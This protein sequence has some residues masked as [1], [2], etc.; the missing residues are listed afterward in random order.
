MAGRMFSFLQNF[1]QMLKKQKGIFWHIFPFG[2]EKKTILEGGEKLKWEKKIKK[3]HNFS[4]W[5]LQGGGAF[6]LPAF[7]ILER[8][9]KPATI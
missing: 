1:K 4:S 9:H 6:I 8:F 3:N 7:Y 2:W 5:I